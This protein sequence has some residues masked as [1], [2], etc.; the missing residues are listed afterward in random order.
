MKDRGFWLQ[1]FNG[2]PYIVDRISRKSGLIPNLSVSLL[3]GIQ[4]EP[5]RRIA[6]EAVDD[7]G[8]Q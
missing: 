7:G 4:P 1:A 2:G 8:G 5:L 6:D 3:G